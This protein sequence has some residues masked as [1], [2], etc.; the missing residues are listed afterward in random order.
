MFQYLE[1][2][3]AV[4]NDSKESTVAY[5]AES[6]GWSDENWRKATKEEFLA[7]YNYDDLVG[8]EGNAL[9]VGDKILCIDG[10][11]KGYEILG[12]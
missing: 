12:L 4:I 2:M 1:T 5:L 9:D 7:F 6:K 3:A 11:I 8:S 10:I